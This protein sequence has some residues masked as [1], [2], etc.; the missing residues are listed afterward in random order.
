AGGSVLG[1]LLHPG[2][3]RYE[4]RARKKAGRRRTGGGRSG[5]ATGRDDGGRGGREH[6]GDPA[7]TLG[8]RTFDPTAG[9]R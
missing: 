6:T 1:A 2:R 7:E 4:R 3:S 5:S 9:H 8:L